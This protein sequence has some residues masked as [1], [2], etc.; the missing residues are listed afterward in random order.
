LNRPLTPPPDGTPRHETD[1]QRNKAAT[2]VRA[3]SGTLLSP[4]IVLYRA[5]R[6]IWRDQASRG[7]LVMAALLLVAGT[8]IFMIIEKF[9]LIDSFYFSF[10]TLAT[11]GYGDFSPSTDLGKLVTV[12]YSFAGLGIM[13]A[14]IRTIATQ[15]RPALRDR[16]VDD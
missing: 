13:A 11:I 14:L 6:A 3:V 4:F 16:T 1:D 15:R 9:S 2:A 5:L 10:I 7:I 8:I 12:I